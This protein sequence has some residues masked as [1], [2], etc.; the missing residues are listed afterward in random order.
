MK[1]IKNEKNKKIKNEK[2]KKTKNKKCKTRW[3]RGGV[4]AAGERDTR[5]VKDLPG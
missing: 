3:G 2:I 4:K 1:K 5:P